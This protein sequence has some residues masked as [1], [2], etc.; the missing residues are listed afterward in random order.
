MDKNTWINISSLCLTVIFGIKGWITMHGIIEFF[1]NLNPWQ[2]S[3][4]GFFIIFLGSSF[5][6]VRGKYREFM[7]DYKKTRNSV[8]QLVKE[9]EKEE[10]KKII[11]SSVRDAFAEVKK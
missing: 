7:K 3:F 5:I 2:F 6:T 1:R 10:I 9:S 11:V 4:M 8:A